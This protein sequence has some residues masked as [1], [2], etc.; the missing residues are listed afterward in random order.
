M[1]P[2]C[3]GDEW[4]DAIDVSEQHCIDFDVVVRH[5]VGMVIVRAGRGTRQ[6]GRWI[7]HTRSAHMAGAIVGSYWHVY[8]SHID[9]HRQAELWMAAIRSTPAALTGGHWAD[10][11]TTDGFDPFELGHYLAAF[12][13][14]MD[15]L[16]GGSVGVFT[17][18]A[19]WRRNVRL[20]ISDRP[21]WIC[22]ADGPDQ[23]DEAEAADVFAVRT[24][25]ADRG[26]PGEHRVH[27]DP[28]GSIANRPYRQLHLVPRR[29]AESVGHWQSRWIRT[30]DVAA[31]QERLN[32]LGADLFVDGVFGPATDR[33]VRTCQLLRRRDQLSPLGGEWWERETPLTETKLA[34]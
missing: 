4:L 26:G 23:F 27:S 11:S 17:R 10:I 25:A 2:R 15:E 13:R 1:T 6:D 30:P 8:P 5:G 19:F 7:E 16:L 9:A 12:L 34:S 24:R 22:A 33:A 14:R 18:D 20:D 31:L 29:P 3:V 21:R 28:F 32:R